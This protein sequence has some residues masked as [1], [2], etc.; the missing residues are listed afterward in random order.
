IQAHA[1]TYAGLVEIGV[2]LVPAWGGCKEMLKRWNART[3][4][5][6]AALK[7][8]ELIA[9]AKVSGS[10]VEARGMGLL[11][12][13]DRITMNRDRLLDDA[14]TRA[15][16]LAVDYHPQPEGGIPLAGAGAKGEMLKQLEAFAAAGKAAPHDLVVGAAL[17]DILTGHE[18]GE[19]SEDDLYIRELG[20][21][22][23]LLRTADTL[24]RIEHM[25][26]TGKPLRN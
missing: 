4:S 22:S 9:T 15:L 6:S 3:D 21:F 14:K 24:S 20:A 26:N 2:G 12:E 16:A 25:L 8:F 11:R 13:D 23:A 10:A 7:A 17:A 19:C 18:A 1:E 5:E